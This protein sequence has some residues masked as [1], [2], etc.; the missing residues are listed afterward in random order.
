[1]LRESP[2]VE[3]SFD[4]QPEKYQ[5]KLTAE[6]LASLDDLLPQIKNTISSKKALPLG[7]VK[8]RYSVIKISDTE[9]Y[10]IGHGS[11]HK[12]VIDSSSPLASVMQKNA[13]VG[14][15]SFGKVKAMA[16]LNRTADGWQSSKEIYVLK[17]FVAPYS[18]PARYADVLKEVAYFNRVY[19]GAELIEAAKRKPNGLRYYALMPKLSGIAVD[20][21]PASQL[22]GELITKII[23]ATYQSISNIH[24]KNLTHGDL[25]L[26]NILYDAQGEAAYITDF[27][28]A[29][30]FDGNVNDKKA[31][32]Y[33]IY[34]LLGKFMREKHNYHLCDYH[35]IKPTNVMEAVFEQQINELVNSLT[36]ETNRFIYDSE[37]AKHIKSVIPEMIAKSV[38]AVPKSNATPKSLL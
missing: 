25:F 30:E 12:T 13:V 14:V 35:S 28:C 10:I 19:G 15:G 11:K 32:G 8:L 1:M 33:S 18:E 36:D 37:K 38:L 29:Y 4:T 6:E 24:N 9:I 5:I 20:K 26:R 7:K 2:Q 21:I 34:Q 3:F 31:F 16:R 23:A 17:K 22:D 27:G